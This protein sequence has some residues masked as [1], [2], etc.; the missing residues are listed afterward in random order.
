ME[1]KMRTA[2]AYGQSKEAG[3]YALASVVNA[4]AA[5]GIKT[6]VVQVRILIP[7]YAFKSRMHTMEKLMKQ[8]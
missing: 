8:V 1:M 2:V 5:E 3:I 6:P 7:E 4:L